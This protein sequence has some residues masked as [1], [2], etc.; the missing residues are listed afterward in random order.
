MKVGFPIISCS[1][2]WLI[3]SANQQKNNKTKTSLQG[4][5]S[6]R[7][8]PQKSPAF[9]WSSMLSPKSGFYFHK[10]H[11]V[12]KSPGVVCTKLTSLACKLLYN[13]KMLLHT[14][15]KRMDGLSNRH[16]SN[17]TSFLSKSSY[18]TEV[19]FQHL[20]QTGTAKSSESYLAK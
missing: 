18:V 8:K 2:L 13:K 16:D 12:F 1:S 19:T 20:P 10:I 11:E 5:S 6:Q 15:L 14:K 9:T 3:F 7:L 4:K 17:F